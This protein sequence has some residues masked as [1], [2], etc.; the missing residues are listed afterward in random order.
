MAIQ[1]SI[2]DEYGVTHDE[3][4][5]IISSVQIIKDSVEI[6]CKT[7]VL[8]KIYHNAAAR[9]KGNSA[10]EKQY[11]MSEWGTIPYNDTDTFF[12]ETLL[13]QADKSPYSQAYAWLKTQSD[14]AGINFTTGTTDV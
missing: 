12:T 2:T 10:N 3:A 5:V 4:Y 6:A 7:L 9:S 14:F 1:K 13:K 11:F 8:T